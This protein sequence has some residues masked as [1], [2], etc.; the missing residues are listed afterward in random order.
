[1]PTAIKAS[2]ATA[3]WQ[4]IA[5]APRDRLLALL[6]R[7]VSSLVIVAGCY[8]RELDGFVMRVPN[9]VDQVEIF[10]SGWAELPGPNSPIAA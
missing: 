10:A 8:S 1:M 7:D 5:S 3:G 6:V 9:S 4:S 2:P